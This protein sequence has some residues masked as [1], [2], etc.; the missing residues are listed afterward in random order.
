MVVAMLAEIFMM[1][2]EVEARLVE[3]ILP[4]STSP[5][6]PFRPSGQFVF[7]ETGLKGDEVT[8]DQQPVKM[9]G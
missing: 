6:I 7:N 9:V 8:R 2:S 1:R 5:F 3:D 4:S